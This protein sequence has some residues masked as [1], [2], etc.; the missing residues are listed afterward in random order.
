MTILELL[1]TKNCY[2]QGSTTR[3]ICSKKEF[4]VLRKKGVSSSYINLW[5]EGENEQE[6]V[7]KFIMSEGG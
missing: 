1:K 6:A 7:Q 5:Y 3:L 4:Q 2:V